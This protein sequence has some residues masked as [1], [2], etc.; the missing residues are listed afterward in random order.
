MLHREIIGFLLRHTQNLKMPSVVRVQNFW[1]LNLLVVLHTTTISFIRLKVN[2]LILIS[3]SCVLHRDELI[4]NYSY[5]ILVQ[6]FYKHF[7]C[8]A[9]PFAFNESQDKHIVYSCRPT[10][11]I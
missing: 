10:Q 8:T 6:A 7:F 2:S 3:A 9:H 11:R 5:Q 4:L 1:T